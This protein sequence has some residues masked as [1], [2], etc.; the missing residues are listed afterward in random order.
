MAL[1][2]IPPRVPAYTSHVGMAWTSTGRRW[3]VTAVVINFQRRPLDPTQCA[4]TDRAERMARGGRRRAGNLPKGRRKRSTPCRTPP[5][6]PGDGSRGP[7]T[8]CGPAP[9]TPGGQGSSHL[10]TPVPAASALGRKPAGFVGNTGSLGR[11]YSAETAETDQYV[12]CHALG[13]G[14][15]ACPVVYHGARSPPS[16]GAADMYTQARSADPWTG[17]CVAVYIVHAVA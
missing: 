8:S 4:C 10:S 17:Q 13:L 2:V 3:R 11:P 5:R 15:G 14:P 16:E 1:E 6:G 9:M 12:G 7:R